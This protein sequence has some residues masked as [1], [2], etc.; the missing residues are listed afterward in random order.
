MI[1]AMDARSHINRFI[2]KPA[3]WQFIVSVLVLPLT[4]HNLLAVLAGGNERLGNPNME[5]I[6][7]T[8]RV[9]HTNNISQKES[10]N[11]QGPFSFKELQTDVRIYRI[12]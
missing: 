11:T 3:R 9:H 4:H 7:R 6:A 5:A 2:Y 8:C 12:V 1:P 10:N